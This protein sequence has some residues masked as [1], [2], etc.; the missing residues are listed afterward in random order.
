VSKTD[1]EAA[2]KAK[3][4][5]I[6]LC[7][8]SSLG[9]VMFGYDTG[10]NGGVQVSNSF[11]ADLCTGVY[12]GNGTNP[13]CT[14]EPCSCSGDIDYQPQAWLTAK[15]EF[16]SMLSVGAMVGAIAGGWVAEKFG[17]RWTVF[18]ASVVFCIATVFAVSVSSV[19]PL[20]AARFLLGV[21]VGLLSFVIPMY[22]AEVAPSELRGVL[23][24]LMQFSIVIGILVAT[25]VAVP[26]ETAAGGWRIALGVCGVPA[27]MLVLGIFYFPESPRWLCKFKGPDEAA[28]ALVALRKTENIHDELSEITTALEEE[29]ES[30]GS[31][32]ELCE[33]GIRNRL[34]VAMG[35]QVL[36]Q[37]TGVNSI[38]YYA[39]SLFGQAGF[40]DPL[41]AGLLCGLANLVGTLLGLRLVDS[42]GRRSLLLIGAAGMVVGMFLAAALLFMF[43]KDENGVMNPL[44][45][46]GVVFFICLFIV[47]FAISWGPICWLYP[48]EIFPMRVRAKAVS[49]STLCNWVMNVIVSDMVPV[50]A[51]SMGAKG[52]FSL[53]SV[54]GVGCWAFV[55]FL[56]PETKGKTLEDIDKMWSKEADTITPRGRGWSSGGTGPPN[57]L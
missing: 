42:A 39:P 38:F 54:C 32:A 31:Y 17:R 4:F 27:A 18:S 44:A 57:T 34:A 14:K 6:M 1:E 2:A 53:F 50:L 52:L 3:T 24:S 11:I 15:G 35:L 20:V 8:F 41:L 55:Y 19:A 10:I 47:F 43:P 5:V 49:L 28:D 12:D 36:Q 13:T 40:Q 21:P 22:A 30:T 45:G 7:L 9:G 29:K 25:V 33:E 48:A 26:I 37:A 23:G 56:V 16:V 51:A 46:Y